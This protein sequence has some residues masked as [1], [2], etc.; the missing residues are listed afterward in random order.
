MPGTRVRRWFAR[1]RVNAAGR[2]GEGR[3]FLPEAVKVPAVNA[4]THK[5][6]IHEQLVLVV[7]EVFQIAQQQSQD[8]LARLHKDGGHLPAEIR[9]LQ[10]RKTF[11]E[12]CP[13]N[14]NPAAGL[15]WGAMLVHRQFSEV[16]ERRESPGLDSVQNGAEPGQTVEQM[17]E[18]HAGRPSARRRPIQPVCRQEADQVIGPLH[19]FVNLS[20]NGGTERLFAVHG[21]FQCLTR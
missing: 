15:A 8:W 11:V 10:Q 7:D 21:D 4:H 9:I 13:V 1:F 16:G 20:Q 3:S 17:T 19:L 6:Q 18:E 2:C 12:V 14:R 5:L